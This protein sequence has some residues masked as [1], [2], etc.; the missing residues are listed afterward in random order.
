MS[1]SGVALQASK[2]ILLLYCE[3]VMQGSNKKKND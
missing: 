1:V 2:A 3:C